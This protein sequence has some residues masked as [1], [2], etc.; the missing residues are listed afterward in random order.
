MTS[1]AII[2][3]WTHEIGTEKALLTPP[4]LS[5]NKANGGID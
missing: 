2:I 1:F 3:N 5:L 4:A